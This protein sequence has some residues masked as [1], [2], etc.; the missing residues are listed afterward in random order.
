VDYFE[1][2]SDTR[3]DKKM[4]VLAQKGGWQTADKREGGIQRAVRGSGK[5]LGTKKGGNTARYQSAG[6]KGEKLALLRH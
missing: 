3:G 5:W 1:N 2:T 6:Q 4:V